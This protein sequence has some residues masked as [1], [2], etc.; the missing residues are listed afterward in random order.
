MNS[1]P[2]SVIVTG[3]AKGIGLAVAKRFAA[4]GARVCLFDLD[5]EG[6][7]AARNAVGGA[8]ACDVTMHQGSVTDAEAVSACAQDVERKWGSVHV[9]VNSAGV[10]M[11]VPSID[12]DEADWRRIVDVNLTGSFLFAR[13]VAKFMIAAGGGCIVNLASIYGRGGAPQRAAYCATK[14]GIV[15]LTQ[16]LASEWAERG[17]RVNAVAPGYTHTEMVSAMIDQGHVDTE[18]VL[19]RTP[20]NRLIE[21]HEV[22]S[23]CAFLCS[24]E[25]AAITGQILGVDGGWHAFGFYS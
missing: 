9:L 4:D 10:A 16:S 22:A 13:T 1:A 17:V 12:M 3:A 2:R 18:S 15:G 5:G 8:G 20:M 25:A 11:A 21:P 7:E 24:A 14:A 6:L 19:K 23:A